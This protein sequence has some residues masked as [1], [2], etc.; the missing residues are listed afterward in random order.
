MPQ[1]SSTSPSRITHRMAAVGAVVTL[2]AMSPPTTARAAAT[3]AIEPTVLG[4]VF[5]DDRTAS[6]VLRST[7]TPQVRWTVTDEQQTV[8]YTATQPTTSGRIEVPE[9]PVGQYSLLVEGVRDQVITSRADTTFALID[10]WEGTRDA[11]FGLNPKFGLPEVAPTWD[12][13]TDTWASEGVPLQS[14][15]TMPL[16]GQ[17]GVSAVRENLPWNN[18]EVEKGQWVL[19]PSWY[20]AYLDGL[21]AQGVGSH[22]LLTYGNKFHDAD[23]EGFGA[24][25]H[26]PEGRAAYAEYARRVVT[27]PGRDIDTVEVWN[28]P[29]SDAPWN[30]GPCAKD[31][32]TGQQQSPQVKA[33]CYYELIRVVTPVVKQAAPDAKVTGPAG[34]TLP[35]AYLEELFRL[36]GLEYLDAIT[37]HPYGFPQTPEAG[38]CLSPGDCGLETR[39]QQL[40]TLIRKYNGGKDKPI[41]FSEIGWGSYTGSTRGVTERQQAD[42][43][44]RAHAIAFANGVE[45]IDWYSMM[46]AKYLPDGPGANWGLIRHPDDPRGAYTPKESFT[47]YTTMTRQLSGKPAVTRDATPEGVRSYRF[48]TDRRRAVED[49]RVMWAPEGIRSA[50]IVA[51]GAVTITDRDGTPLLSLG[52]GRSA[53]ISLDSSPVYVTGNVR[54]L[55]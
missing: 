55:R 37:V 9:L 10:A 20:D 12:P 39:I 11:R 3:V 16:L 7:E 51:G 54:A 46:N 42:Y 18:L 8:M 24:F 29:N 50:T 6:F 21:E 13:E 33:A 14:T 52:S 45:R 34:V 26:T 28:E 41:W 15:D 17:T 47:A 48:A 22:I 40:R 31:P 49:T 35:Y 36:G 44:V 19:G 38:Y 27:R 30:R 1:R 23:A 4:N 32:Q 25:P 5:V 43:M 53:T 2:V